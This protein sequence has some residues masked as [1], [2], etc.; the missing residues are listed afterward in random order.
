MRGLRCFKQRKGTVKVVP[1]F[2]K[3]HGQGNEKV[4]AAC[5][6]EVLGKRLEQGKICF[7]V[8]ES[9][10]KGSEI[11]E[12]E[13]RKKLHEFENINLVGN[14]AVALALEEKLA[15]EENVMEIAGTKHVQIFK[16]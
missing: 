13:L 14:K 15:L 1:I 5:D 3:V 11:E 6:K 12:A 10:Y 7:E 8:K 16:I 4:L 9:F 2:H